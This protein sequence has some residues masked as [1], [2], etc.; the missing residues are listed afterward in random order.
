LD[1]KEVA[2]LIQSLVSWF[3]NNEIETARFSSE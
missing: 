2:K 3:A 1:N